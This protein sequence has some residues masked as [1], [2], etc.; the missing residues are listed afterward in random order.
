MKRR[1][2]SS[3]EG[4]LLSYAD[5]I[6][7][8]LI[9]FAML[10]AA[11][12]INKTRMQ[13]ITQSISGKEQPASLSSIQ[14]EIEQKIVEE[15]LQELVRTDLTDD[16]LKLSLNSGLVFDSGSG[17]IRPESEPVL[18]KM[19]RTLV[20]YAERY[21]FAVEGHTDTA[22][23]GVGSAYLSN[24]EL[25]AARANAVRSRLEGVGI[26]GQRVRVEGYADTVA[27]PESDLEG[28]TEAERLARHR[29]VVVRVY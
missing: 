8:L 14:E 2:Y 11:A 19:L 6:T 26:E 9:F 4:W 23:V 15:G 12:D 10:L 27:L 21:A 17:D 16:G 28:L 7:N 25:S 13:Q 20:P 24:W 18:D 1:S 22:A 3:D 5:L 29:R